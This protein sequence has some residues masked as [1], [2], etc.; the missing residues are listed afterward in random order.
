MK[1]LTI[2][3]IAI[4]ALAIG[5]M[6]V[7]AYTPT[8]PADA[9]IQGT[10]L[11]L[12]GGTLQ[13]TLELS[14]NPDITTPSGENLDIYAASGQTVDI[15]RALNTCNGTCASCSIAGVADGSICADGN[16]EGNQIRADGY[17]WAF[18]TAGSSDIIRAGGG[19][20]HRGRSLYVYQAV[21][22][23]TVTEPDP[24][25]Y[26]LRD[27]QY[28]GGTYTG[29]LVTIED[30]DGSDSTGDLISLIK[31]STE[32]F[33]VEDDGIVY[34]QP[35]ACSA[36]PSAG[37]AGRSRFVTDATVSN[38]AAICLDDGSAWVLPDGS[39]TACCP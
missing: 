36:L 17:M 3:T 7:Y 33:A 37:T 6:A 23:V 11:P 27:N 13:G 35:V 32:R 24:A 1:K 10:G 14:A 26:I 16:I 18:A 4:I 29:P 20:A 9:A 22:N 28:S 25:A 19:S 39:G 8:S 34:W 5:A 38:D 31:D 21:L 12:S 2:A 15:Y 30:K